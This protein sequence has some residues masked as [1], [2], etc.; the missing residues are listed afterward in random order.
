MSGDD[1]A[2][3]RRAPARLREARQAFWAS[4]W[5]LSCLLVFL[6]VTVFVAEP[7]IAVGPVG[8]AVLGLVFSAVLVTGIIAVAKSRTVAIAFGSVA[9]ASVAIHWV[10]YATKDPALDA[11]N[12][13]GTLIACGM[14]AAIVLV[15]VF[16][17]GSITL[18]RVQGA[19]CVYLL[20]GMMWAAIYAL[21][22]VH[23]PN[24]FDFGRTGTPTSAIRA[25][26]RFVY[27]SLTTLTTVGY[28]DIT[29]VS[30]I[31]R[32]MAML[33][34]VTGQLFPAILIARLVS[35]E[36]Y[37]RQRRFEREQAALDRDALAHE[38]ARVLREQG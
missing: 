17:E 38:V 27:F 36:L 13:I 22:F 26:V 9:I 3:H 33:E 29:A 25:R 10:H 18:H 2:A 4:E 5:S 12:A 8:H 31:A 30:P 34:A 6:V 16:R 14:L 21:I 23:D 19:I 28:G 37:Y 15:Q 20:L 35:M 7:L 1:A 32:S 11:L 24:A